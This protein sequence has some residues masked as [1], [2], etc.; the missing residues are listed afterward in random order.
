MTTIRMNI[1]IPAQVR[2]HMREFDAK[3]NWSAIATGAFQ[4]YMMH[5]YW[6]E[7]KAQLRPTGPQ[8]NWS[9][10]WRPFTIAK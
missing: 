9:K 6:K 8:C 3:A 10:S 4:K 1:S 7:R 5:Q 2:D